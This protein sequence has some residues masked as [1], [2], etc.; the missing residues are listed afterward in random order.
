MRITAVI[1]TKLAPLLAFLLLTITACTPGQQRSQAPAVTSTAT[2]NA[3]TATVRSTPTAAFTQTATAS[4]AP[5]PSAAV[6]P[7]GSPTPIPDE[8]YIEDIR[9][10]R[11]SFP[12]GCE[13]SQAVDW[14][15]YYGVSINE[16][17]F[18]YRLP[19]SDNPDIGFVGSVDAPWGQVPPYGYGVHAGPVADLLTEYG[20]PARGVKGAAL[21]EVK[22][23]VA[24][25]NPVIAWVIGNVVGGVPFEYTDKQGNKVIVAAY[26]HVVM[27]IGYREG[28]IRYMTNGRMFELPE[29][30]FLNSWGVLGNMALFRD[31]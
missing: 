8:F 12:L 31:E 28:T 11:Q 16:F 7:T 13:A 1:S 9:G 10:H 6:E 5:S 26:E 2:L 18:Q 20:L 17:E 14:A 4:P 29:D 27:V 23:S 15:T 25:G 21:D 3:P 24:A 19:S 30:N 22:A